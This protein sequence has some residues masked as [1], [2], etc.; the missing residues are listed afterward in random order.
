MS[1]TYPK[2]LGYLHHM[3]PILDARNGFSGWERQPRADAFYALQ[4]IGAYSFEPYKVAWRYIAADFVVAVIGPAADG[5][6]P[7]CNDKV[8]FVACSGADEAY[9]LGGLLSSDAVRWCVTATMTGTQISTSA[10]RHLALPRFDAGDARHAAIARHC[11]EGHAHVH[12]GERGAAQQ[13][14]DAINATAADLFALSA[15]Q[16]SAFAGPPRFAAD[17]YGSRGQ[18]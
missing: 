2:S 13:A 1:T 11:A 4:R 5:R 6:P 16:R 3:R 9:F 8:M 18:V 14:L 10:I 12:A 7:L 15:P 17:A